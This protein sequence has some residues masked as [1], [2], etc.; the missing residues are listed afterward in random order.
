MRTVR[1]H[2]GAFADEDGSPG[3]SVHNSDDDMTTEDEGDGQGDERRRNGDQS[4]SSESSEPST[5]SSSDGLA[6]SGDDEAND[7][8]NVDDESQAL[9]FAERVAMEN[10]RSRRHQLLR[11]SRRG[12]T[13]SSLPDTQDGPNTMKKPK[14]SFTREN[15]HRPVEM[16][17]KKR[18]SVLRDATLGLGDG[19]GLMKKRHVRDPRFDELAGSY[20]EKAFKKRYSFIFDEKLPEERREL[21]DS[22]S[23]IKSDR[24]KARLQKK[25][26]R[27]TQQ[28]KTEENRRKQEARREKVLQRHK[29]ATKGQANKYHLKKSDVKKQELVLKYQELKESGGLERYMEKRRKRNA[30]KD[31]RYLPEARK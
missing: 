4:G 13:P 16:S 18:V 3:S 26:Q 8:A 23:K 27:I 30:A 12:S 7:E 22:L 2:S 1:P 6:S 19:S 31:H 20:S 9:S 24:K 21:K 25:L 17:S 29:E 15:K 11:A 28:I 10:R 14:T 5:S